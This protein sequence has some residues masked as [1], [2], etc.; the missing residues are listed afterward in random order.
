MLRIIKKYKFILLVSLI[1]NIVILP[2]GLTFTD[3]T[4]TLP[5]GL[6]EVNS[7]IDFDTNNSSSGSISSIFIITPYRSTKLELWWANNF[8]RK[9]SSYKVSE[10][11]SYYTS[12]EKSIQGQIQYDSSI[13][14][15]LIVSYSEANKKGNNYFLDITFNGAAINGYEKDASIFEVGDIITK[16]N[17]IDAKTNETLFIKEFNSIFNEKKDSNE[18]VILR[19]G[20]NISKNLNFLDMDTI[21]SVYRSY[22]NNGKNSYPQYTIKDI[23]VGGPSGG[24]LQTLSIYNDLIDEDITYGKKISGTGTIN[25]DGTVGAIGGIK[26][27]IYTADKNDVDIFFCPESNYDDALEAYN[28]LSK[29]RQENMALVS[30]STFTNAIDYLENVVNK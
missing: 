25:V 4:I 1:L 11:S 21:T 30:V 16:V 27:K 9:S 18:V 3:E 19:N 2:F 15:S 5:G 17:G 13:N 8:D 22:T 28:T 26:Q 29:S 7:V 12:K 20:E 24:L 6:N 10:Y 23:N 14:Q